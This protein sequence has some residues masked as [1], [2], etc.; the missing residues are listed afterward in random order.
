MIGVGTTAGLYGAPSDTLDRAWLAAKDGKWFLLGR[1]LA[2]GALSLGAA[3][4]GSSKI[5]LG[6]TAI[7][8]YGGLLHLAMDGTDRI[9][10]YEGALGMS[11]EDLC[12]LAGGP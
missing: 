6:V 7:A 1:A 8:L 3:R 11:L 5:G 10:P 2:G 12:A 9:L 4:V